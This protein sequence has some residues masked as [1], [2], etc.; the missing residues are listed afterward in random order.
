MATPPFQG[1]C[2]SGSEQGS[3]SLTCHRLQVSSLETEQL[4]R[5]GPRGRS[6]GLSVHPG[7]PARPWPSFTSSWLSVPCIHEMDTS[8]SLT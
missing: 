4:L 2:P 6:L 3:G 8:P 1:I 7:T 5:R